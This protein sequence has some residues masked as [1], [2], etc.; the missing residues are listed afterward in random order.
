MSALKKE[1]HEYLVDCIECERTVRR[2]DRC[3][4]GASTLMEEYV[5]ESFKRSHARRVEAGK[6]P[7][8]RP[9]VIRR[10]GRNE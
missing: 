6:Y 8:I 5:E 3:A 4:C 1:F 9:V 2:G 10:G 7:T